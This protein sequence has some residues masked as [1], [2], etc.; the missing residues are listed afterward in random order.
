MASLAL[1]LLEQPS[2]ADDFESFTQALAALPIGPLPKQHYT[3]N[4]KYTTAPVTKC[5]LGKRDGFAT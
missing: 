1:T 4:Q 2:K 5:F 3:D